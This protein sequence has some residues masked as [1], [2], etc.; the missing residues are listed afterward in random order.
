MLGSVSI[1]MDTMQIASR[2]TDALFEFPCIVLDSFM[3]MT[4]LVKL[5]VEKKTTYTLSSFS[6][7][8]VMLT[9]SAQFSTPNSVLT[10]QTHCSA[11]PASLWGQKDDSRFMLLFP[12]VAGS[13]VG[14]PVWEVADHVESVL[15]QMPLLRV[16]PTPADLRASVESKSR[17]M[18]NADKHGI[19]ILPT[20]VVCRDENEFYNSLLTAHHAHDGSKIR[21]VK[22]ADFQESHIDWLKVT[23]NST[24]A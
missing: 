6:Q 13:N 10:K 12:L 11:R 21:I 20:V 9:E 4:L 8:K 15:S 16:L 2:D 7:F 1:L 14:M 5:D 17:Y 3:L 19:P 23:T 22:H 18:I 24:S